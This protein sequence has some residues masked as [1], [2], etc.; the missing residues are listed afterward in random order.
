LGNS[1]HKIVTSK[2]RL[3]DADGKLYAHATCSC[4]IFSG[5]D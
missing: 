2:A 4:L 5:E 3:V 1:H